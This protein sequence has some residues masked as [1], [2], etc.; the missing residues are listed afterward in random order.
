MTVYGIGPH[1]ARNL[2]ARGLRTIDDLEA[3][4]DLDDFRA[5]RLDGTYTGSSPDAE[6]ALKMSIL[7]ALDCRHELIET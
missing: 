6:D 3:L 2:Y 5:A 7:V 1:T 4:Y